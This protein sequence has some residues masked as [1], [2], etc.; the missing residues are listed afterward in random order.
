MQRVAAGLVLIVLPALL[1]VAL[2][3]GAQ[4]PDRPPQRRGFTWEFFLQ[5]HD[6]DGD[7]VV[8]RGEFR[9]ESAFFGQ[10]DADGDGRVTET[11]FEEHN[12]NR[13][14]QW[15][16]RRLP[17]G[18][19]ALRDLEYAR[20]G[21]VSLKLD[22]YLPAASE[23]KPPLF[24]WVH[25]GGWR[26]GSKA[27]VN[28]CVVRLTGDGYATASIDYRLDGLESH[29][30]QIHDCKGAVRWLRAHA[31]DYGY[32]PDRI[33]VGGGSAGGHLA[34]LLGL[35]ASV[36]ELEGEV[37]GNLDQSSAVLAIV[38]LFGPS[39]WT[40][41]AASRRGAGRW[42]GEMLK[43]AGPLTYLDGGD[44]PVIIIHGDQD[45]TVPLSQSE[46]LHER[47]QQA[48]LESSLHVI[49]GAGH[50]GL[51]FSDEERY[52]LIREFLDRHLKG[53]ED[54]QLQ[55]EPQAPEPAA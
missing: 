33:A 22:L 52:A 14:R 41:R 31:D 29:P 9:G 50:G 20:V 3:C 18:T 23:G 48:G 19:R 2:P 21:D 32:D 35:S 39:D 55:A 40:S 45:Q 51:E 44:P 28:P 53:E 38:D 7:G 16:R 26:N 12:A 42:R 17:E 13:R 49:E 43:S 8:A 54:A 30:N 4:Q 25:G 10:L 6:D 27:M 11:E 15:G 46:L 47:Y 5:R 1:G 34:L 37:G 24:V 36:P